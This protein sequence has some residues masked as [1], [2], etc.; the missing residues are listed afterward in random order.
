[1]VVLQTERL[2]LRQLREDDAPFIHALLND[3]SFLRFI[4]DR[5]IRDL[6]GARR[7]IKRRVL[8]SY[9]RNGYGLYLVV[10]KADGRSVGIC[11]LVKRDGLDDTDIGFAFISDVHGLGYASEASRA[12]ME[13]GRAELGLQRIVAITTSENRGSLAVLDKLGLVHVRNVTLPGSA[14]ELMLLA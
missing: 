4:G 3:P 9:E 10:Q 5:G 6:D 13:F 11:G 1:M 14:D 2:T 12:V 7:Y 8:R